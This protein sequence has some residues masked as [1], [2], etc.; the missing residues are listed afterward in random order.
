MNRILNVN[1]IQT[2]W[3]L[4][5]RSCHLGQPRVLSFQDTNKISSAHVSYFITE[6]AHL[7]VKSKKLERKTKLS[8][9]TTIFWHCYETPKIKHHKNL[10]NWWGQEQNEP[11]CR[12]GNKRTRMRRLSSHEMMFGLWTCFEF[13]V[14][15]CPYYEADG[16]FKWYIQQDFLFNID[17]FI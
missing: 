7:R 9:E 12:G 6:I 14:D 8:M 1:N 5:L 15:L 11:L 10:I 2:M 3:F 17:V 4:A 16:Y 13:L